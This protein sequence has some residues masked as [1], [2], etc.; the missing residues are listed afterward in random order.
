MTILAALLVSL[1]ALAAA[2]AP[3]LLE[4]TA[5]FG[6]IAT[7]GAEF[8]DEAR[9]LEGSRVRFRAFAVIEPRPSGVV[10]LTRTPEARLHPDDEDTL[11]WDSIAALFREG[12]SPSKLSTRIVVEGVLRLGN[13]MV[14]GETVVAVL[15]DA[16]IVSPRKR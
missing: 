13:R 15:E 7:T 1:S 8:S 10:Y 3:P 6:R 5:L 14:A 9:K 12:R 16:E 2:P 4:H 11:P